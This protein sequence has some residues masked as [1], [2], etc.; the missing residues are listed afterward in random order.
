MKAFS[1]FCYMLVA[2]CLS[3]CY[4]EEHIWWSPKGDRAIVMTDDH[5]L[6]LVTVDGELGEALFEGA[7]VEDWGVMHLSWFPDGSGFVCSRALRIRSWEETKKLIPADEAKQVENG[8]SDI[9]P[10]LQWKVTQIKDPSEVEKLSWFLPSDD[11]AVVE[12]GIRLLWEQQPEELRALF[13][14]LPHGEPILAELEGENTGFDVRE[15]CLV[16]LDK[17]AKKPMQE[18]AFSLLE[19]PIM[20]RVSLKH[21]ALAYLRFKED[22]DDQSA[23]LCV[24]RVDSGQT[25]V[26]AHQVSSLNFKWMPDGRSLV[27]TQAP[28][29]KADLFQSIQQVIALQESGELMKPTNEKQPDGSLL[30]IEGTDRLAPPKPLALAIMSNPGLQIGTTLEPLPDGRILFASQPITLPALA[31]PELASQLFLISADGQSLSTIPTK[32][33][34]LPTDLGWFVLSPDGKSV[35]IVEGSTDAV[36]VVEVSTGKT[37]II[38]PPHEDWDCRTVPSWRSAT[39]LTFAA[40]DPESKTTQWMLWSAAKGTRSI[41]KK[42]PAAAISQWLAAPKAKSP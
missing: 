37:E 31:G 17:S 11:K 3:G 41:S 27:F 42:W 23:V 35:A 18:F 15:L 28:G 8:L 7:S 39:E 1:R 14:Q 32:P 2:V 6:H 29:G 4:P 33:G 21:H 19:S 26:V 40:V 34:D 13:R 36:A 25:L 20:P 22:G 38:S 10:T 5:K 9:M 30:K 16:D 12:A 24:T